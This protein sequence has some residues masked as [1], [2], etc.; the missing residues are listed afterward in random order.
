[1]AFPN[2]FTFLLGLAAVA[3]ATGCS[4]SPT[5]P[6][7]PP[8]DPYPDGP[9]VLCP[10]APP[11][12]TSAN[13]SP[14]TVQYGTPTA[15]GGA[16]Q[17]TV[18][19]APAS[20]S[21][22]NVGTTTVTC[23]AQDSR[24]RTD[25]CSFSVVVLQP[26]KIQLTRFAAFGDSITWG[27]NGAVFAPAGVP[28]RLRPYFQVSQNYPAVLYSTLQGRYSTQSIKVGNFGAPGEY[29]SSGDTRARFSSIARSGEYDVILL[30]EGSNDIGDGLGGAAISSLRSMIRDGLSRGVKVY[31]G[32]IPPMDG[33]SCCPRRGSAAPLVPGYNDQ[34]RAL[35]S[36]EGVPLVDVYAALADSPLT[37]LSADGLHPNEA[38]YAKI[39]DR[40]FTTIKTN[41]EVTT[42]TSSSPGS[43]LAVPQSGSP[44]SG[45]RRRP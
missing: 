3:F 40:F 15:S 16:P 14:M 29:A 20:G 28:D 1:M 27:E 45:F 21:T 39:A 37:Y 44:Y 32:T 18:S 2:R 7:T 41:L 38:G 25:A 35:A 6:T 11:A 34:L 9:K 10:A 30:M 5:K 13:G 19:C 12:A 36:S 43:F 22:F 31:L 33:A 23:T 17:V 24:Q 42:T 8:P 26:P 4:S